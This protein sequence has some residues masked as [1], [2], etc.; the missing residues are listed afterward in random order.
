[1]QAF[2]VAAGSLSS[3]ALAIISGV[4]L[5]RYFDKIE[6]GT[7]RQIIYVYNTLLV[8]FS[9]GLPRVFSYFLP[10][11]NIEEGKAIVWKIS[12]MLFLAGAIFSLSLFLLSETIAELL[13]NKELALGLRI[14]SP[15]PMLLLPTLG[16][17]GI[18]STYKKTIYIAIYNTV[19]RILMLLFIVLPVTLFQGN[20]ITAIYGWLVVSVITLF[21]A[22]SFKGIPFKG[23]KTVN[24]TLKFKEIFAYSIPLV[25]ASFWGIAIKSADQFYISRYFGPEIFAEFANGFIQLPFVGMV[26]SATSVVLMPIFS[27]VFH[28]GKGIDNLLLTW[29]NALK[30]SALILYPLLIFFMAFGPQI[31]VLLYSKRYYESGSYFQINM[32][33]NFF[34]IIIFAPLFF[35]MGKTKEYAKVHMIL[36][37]IIWSTH[38]ILIQIFNSPYS[39]AINSTFWSIAKILYFIH[40]ASKYMNVKFIEFFPIKSLLIL[41][42]HSIAV[43]LFVKIT[44]NYLQSNLPDFISL[45]LSA[46]IFVILLILTSRFFNLDYLSILRPFINKFFK[47]HENNNNSRSSS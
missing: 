31:M 28:E 44:F 6:Y 37:L 8:I 22:Y 3:F 46:L 41:L 15:I 21:I 7:Y 13:K 35:S 17:E 39:I 18:F 24:T 19:T 47:K 4:I 34:N 45:S 10:R 12:K 29:R 42:C 2:W 23:V 32:F 27:K 36:A 16:I 5:S 38:Y 14:F 30:K 40:L 9:A 25:I 26:T 33:L 1:M 11:F 43:V 20:Y